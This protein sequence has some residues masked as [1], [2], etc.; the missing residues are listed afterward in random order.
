[1]ASKQY[2]DCKIAV[3]EICGILQNNYIKYTYLWTVNTIAASP[4]LA[5]R[6]PKMPQKKIQNNR[7]LCDALVK[8]WLHSPNK[9]MRVLKEIDTHTLEIKLG[10]SIWLTCPSIEN[11]TLARTRKRAYL[12]TC[13]ICT[14]IG[15][16][17]VASSQT[18]LS[19]C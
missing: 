12:R 11:A 1:M 14:F 6:L 17:F 7:M 5:E 13:E 2:P 4:K 10:A 9:N 16:T 18:C 3:G 8:A 19:A 15:Q